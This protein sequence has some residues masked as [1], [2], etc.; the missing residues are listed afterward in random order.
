[1]KRF[2]VF[3]LCSIFFVFVFCSLLTGCKHK[4]LYKL[5]DKYVDSLYTEYE[6]YGLMGGET[7]LTPDGKYQVHPI[8]RLVNVKIMAVVDDSVYEKLR[9]DLASHYKNDKKVYDVYISKVGTIM[10]DCRNRE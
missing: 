7:E 8:G 4:D 2:L 5:T 6:S 9:D 3:P 10:I 1:M